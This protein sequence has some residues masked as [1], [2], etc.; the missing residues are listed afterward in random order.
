MDVLPKAQ[1]DPAPASSVSLSDLGEITW[2]V[3]HVLDAAADPD[4]SFEPFAYSEGLLAEEGVPNLY[5]SHTGRCGHRVGYE[6]AN[7]MVNEAARRLIDGS[8]QMGGSVDVM[9]EGDAT[10]RLELGEPIDIETSRSLEVFPRDPG[11][12]IPITW[13]CSLDGDWPG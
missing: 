7:F 10:L 11:P 8:A 1:P 2:T 13:I 5:L 3:T 6:M 12:V 9:T 4:P